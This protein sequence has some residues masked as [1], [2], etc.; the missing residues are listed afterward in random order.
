MFKFIK[1]YAETI[2]GI[3]IYP[4]VSMLIFVTFFLGVI[5]YVFFLNKSYIT[6][7]EQMPLDIDNGQTKEN[8]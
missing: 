2:V 6:E 8:N 4:L 5:A 3:E 1:Q 7:L